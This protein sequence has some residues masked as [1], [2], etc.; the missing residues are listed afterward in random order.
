[1]NFCINFLNYFTLLLFFLPAFYIYFSESSYLPLVLVIN[2]I[3]FI[4]IFLLNIYK[5]TYKITYLYKYTPFKHLIYLF[6]WMVF[7]SIC[8]IFF[9]YISF[10][11]FIWAAV[12]GL[13]CRCLLPYLYPS[14]I[15]SY[16]IHLKTLI[17]IFCF[18]YIVIFI[19]GFLEFWGVILDI[20]FINQFIH[21]ISNARPEDSSIIIDNISQIPRIRSVFMEPGT[22]GRFIAINM[23]LIYH[24]SLTT[25]K[26]FSN[27]VLNASIKKLLIPFMVISLILTQSPIY[28]VICS[29]ITVLYFYKRIL[30][31]IHSSIKIILLTL[32]TSFFIIILL[33]QFDLTSLESTYITRIINVVSIIHNFSFEKL[34]EIEPSLG[35]RI[36]CYA[37]LF[38]L[39]LKHPLFGIGCFYNGP[40]LINQFVTSNIPLTYEMMVIVYSGTQTISF[41][42]NALYSLLYQA[43]FISVILYFIFIYKTITSLKKL[44]T[45]F[46]GIENCFVDGLSKTLLVLFYISIIYNQDYNDAYFFFM[47]GLCPYIYIS[48]K[49]R[50][51]II[52]KTK[53]NDNEK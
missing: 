34:I 41:C 31:F 48:L 47:L 24:F 7:S 2:T 40:I 3:C 14:I 42:T 20:K 37:N 38:E 19:L 26:I 18:V 39:F 8:C 53:E 30:K 49:Q 10:M 52:I 22:Y 9:G 13:L 35:T 45:Q 17:K 43:G 6:L 46:S 16:K 28:L 4:F 50:K 12:V 44:K 25:Y 27:R 5:N 32:S 11:K 29:L 33:F 51:K 21:F 1:M 23:P 36:V 15:M